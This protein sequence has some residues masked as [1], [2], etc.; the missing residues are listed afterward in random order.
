MV[1]SEFQGERVPR[2]GEIIEEFRGRLKLFLDVNSGSL[3]V[4]VRI[5][6]ETEIFEDVFVWLASSW[7][8]RRFRQL[9]PGVAMKRNI[10]GIEQLRTAKQP[11]STRVIEVPIHALTEELIALAHPRA[12]GSWPC[13]AETQGNKRGNGSFR[14]T[15]TT[16][17]DSIR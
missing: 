11:A 7:K 17:K 1:F 5:I 4:L 3:K 12:Y 13:A 14:A 16:T 2:I 8:E 9:S 10:G 6:R 15:S